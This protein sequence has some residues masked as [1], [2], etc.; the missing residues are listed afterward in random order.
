MI[1][2]LFTSLFR[3]TIFWYLIGLGYLFLGNPDWAEALYKTAQDLPWVPHIPM[4]GLGS[5]A[6]VQINLLLYWTLPVLAIWGISYIAGIC[7]AE[8][9]CRYQIHHNKMLL[10]P[11]GNFW[12]V[13]VAGFSLGSLPEATTPALTGQPVNFKNGGSKVQGAAILKVSKQTDEAVKFLTNTERGVCEELLQLLLA[14]P[15]HFAGLGHGVGLLEHTL[16]VVEAAADK[17]TSEFRMPLLAALAHDVGKLVTF[18]IHPKTGEWYRKGL[19][20]R[21]SARILATLPSFAKLPELH[22]RALLLAVKYDHNPNKMPEVGADRDANMLAMRTIAAL[23][24]ADRKATAEEKDRNL[25]K[26]KPEDLVWQDFVHNFR[27]APVITRGKKGGQNHINNPSD[28][29]YIFLY[30]QVWREAA[31]DRLPP[32]VA[33][34]LDLNR[35]DS[36][37]VAKYTKILAE[38]LIKKGV[39]LT[40]TLCTPED[41]EPEE[42]NVHPTN[43]LWDIRSGKGEGAQNMR[44]V[45]VLK[46]DPLWKELNYRVAKTSPFPVTITQPNAGAT[47]KVNPA[48]ESTNSDVDGVNVGDIDSPEAQKAVGFSSDR[49]KVRRISGTTPAAKEVKSEVPAQVVT[50]P[51]SVL[52]L[53]ATPVKENTAKVVTEPVANEVEVPGPVTEQSVS[54]DDYAEPLDDDIE[55]V[56]ESTESLDSALDMVLSLGAAATPADQAADASNEEPVSAADTTVPESPATVTTQDEPK[57]EAVALTRSEENFGVGLATADDVAKYPHLV[58]GQKFLTERSRLVQSGKVA[59]GTVYAP[60]GKLKAENPVEPPQKPGIVPPKPQPATV[61]PPEPVKQSTASPPGLAAEVNK[62]T[63]PANKPRKVRRFN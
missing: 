24:T 63:P 52:G 25:V 12:G 38:I 62:T 44:G 13:Q 29:P 10:Q 53:S 27:D 9:H 8:L 57:A 20:S 35:R 47:G 16:N 40:K 50:L 2:S 41:G 7:A 3:V 32:E 37:K 55:Q 6:A 58:I 14:Q 4:Y 18:R 15:D 31:I 30:E 5:A 61:A 56:Q 45:I 28:S 39:L 36:G 22:Q 1:T 34:A 49:V 19:H 21:E 42:K 33:A 48:Y 46:K 23:A 59:V 26:L 11:A 54:A 17:C 60:K 51:D 43:P